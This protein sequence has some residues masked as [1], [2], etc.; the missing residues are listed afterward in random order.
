MKTPEKNRD[1]S[2]APTTT[3]KFRSASGPI[4]DD[5]F[6]NDYEPRPATFTPEDRKE[7]DKWIAG[8]KAATKKGAA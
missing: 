2:K 8:L 7:F 5:H 6:E 4:P 3:T 1:S